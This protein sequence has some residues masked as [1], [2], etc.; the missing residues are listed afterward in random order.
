MDISGNT[1]LPVPPN[2]I[3]K[4]DSTEYIS[5]P[6]NHPTASTTQIQA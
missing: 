3:I 4:F 2:D 1:Y 6:S 5:V